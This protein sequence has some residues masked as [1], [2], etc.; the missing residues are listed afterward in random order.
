MTAVILHVRSRPPRPNNLPSNR[1]R[2]SRRHS[3][4]FERWFV[5]GWDVR[6]NLITRVSTANQLCGVQSIKRSTNNTAK[7][8]FW[9]RLK[10]LL[11]PF[12][13]TQQT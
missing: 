12:R 4:C 6:C 9:N 3:F 11:K 2:S 1:P 5:C 10:Y 13:V 7:N 8:L